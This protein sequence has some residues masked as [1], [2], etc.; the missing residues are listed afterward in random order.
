MQCKARKAEYVAKVNA[1]IREIQIRKN[2]QTDTGIVHGPKAFFEDG[3]YLTNE[4]KALRYAAIVKYGNRCVCCGRGPK[5][6]VSIHVDH[7]KPKSL[8]PQQ[9]LDIKNLQILCSDCNIGKKNK[10]RIDWANL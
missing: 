8:W 4:W 2:H 3:W 7:I 6:G 5:E 10:D 9:A 1:L